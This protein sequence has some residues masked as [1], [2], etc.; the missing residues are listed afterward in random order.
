M[1]FDGVLLH[2]ER[3]RKSDHIAVVTVIEQVN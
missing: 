1:M 3:S 2:A